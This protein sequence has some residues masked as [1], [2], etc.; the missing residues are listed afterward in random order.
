MRKLIL[1]LIDPFYPLFSR[2]LNIENYRYAVCGSLNTGLDIILY[3]IFYH[4]VLDKE[5]VNLDLLKISPHIAAFLMSFAITF[6]I[7]FF[8]MRG[9]VFPE[10]QIRGR[11]QLARYFSVVCLNLLLNYLFLKLFVDILGMY[12]TPSK[13][14]ITVI[15][16]TITYLLQKNF[17]FKKP[18][19]IKEEIGKVRV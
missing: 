19:I 14:A 18:A 6:P 7:G 1:S 13:M 15:I 5:I 2:I 11:V 17:T 12:P 8:L 3:F 16:V 9:I 4:F 10:S